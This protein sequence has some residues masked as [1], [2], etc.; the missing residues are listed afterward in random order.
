[1]RV[2][3]ARD[4]DQHDTRWPVFGDETGATRGGG[5]RPEAEER[6]AHVRA[7]E[8]AEA[9]EVTLLETR[10]DDEQRAGRRDHGGGVSRLRTSLAS[11]D[12]LARAIV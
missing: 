12:P 11:T 5:D 7:R 6:R 8:A 10:R 4:A 9:L 3:G 2:V 1:M